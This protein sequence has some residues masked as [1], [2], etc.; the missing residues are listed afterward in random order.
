MNINDYIDGFIE[1]FLFQ[2]NQSEIK[3]II[4]ISKNENEINNIIKK[5]LEY[6]NITFILCSNDFIFDIDTFLSEL[7]DSE[8][9]LNVKITDIFDKY[10]SQKIIEYLDKNINCDVV[11]S[12]YNISKKY[13]STNELIEIKY[14][15]DTL[16]LKNNLPYSIIPHR[17][18][19]RKGI[20]TFFKLFNNLHMNDN[21]IEKYINCNL[22]VI[23]FSSK[24]L[25]TIFI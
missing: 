3:L 1:Q 25:Y 2:K 8:Y 22:N 20:Y 14:K 11:L 13:K 12:T 24:P 5:Y 17:F 6:K 19:W 21:I 7:T 10:Y 23:S 4:F 16:F 15:K 9:L 18:V